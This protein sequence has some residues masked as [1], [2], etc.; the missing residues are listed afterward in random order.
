MNENEKK[1]LLVD[2]KSFCVAPWMS[3]YVHPNGN[4]LPCCIWDL[5]DPLG[6]INKSSLSEIYQ[7][8]KSKEIKG[9][10]LNGEV[11]KQCSSCI[12]NEKLN[13]ES[14]RQRF[15]R[16]HSK[17]VEYV[18]EDI[19]KFHLWDVRITNLC[20]FKCR[21]CYHG[22]SSSWFNDAVSMNL[23]QSDR[24]IITLD[25]TNDFLSQL[26]EHYEHVEEIYFAGGEPLISE[27]HYQILDEIIKRNKQVYLR[28]STNLSKM[29]FKDKHIFDYWSHFNNI[30][31]FP[32]LDGLGSVGEYIRS[33]FKTEVFIDNAKKV[34]EFLT[35]SHIFYTFSF[36]ALNYLH[37]FDMVI[38]LI[39]Q[40][41]I[42]KNRDYSRR[43][44]L[45]INPIYGPDHLSCKW[46]SDNIKNRFKTRLETF[47]QE[48]ELLGVSDEVN[49]EI[50]ELLGSI[51]L[52]SVTDVDNLDRF[53][54]Y[55]KFKK[56]NDTLD[57][58]RLEKFET[59]IGLKFY[60]E[61]NKKMI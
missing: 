13:I 32:S 27:H 11:V 29:T 43:R 39:N 14:Y 21:M 19:T 48:L 26:T 22:F 58:L 16:D 44:M 15:N 61:I 59:E 23:T 8:D 17:C 10:M 45:A 53:D 49:K 20:N 18:E 34:S 9:K 51:Y 2:S 54:L 12:N 55:Q 40:G 1:S 3:V 6:N 47:N 7:S 46:I 57:K 4:V 56:Y 36:G 28:Y 30:T 37:T 33:G 24:A 25:D 42:E 52:F 60:T 5:N 31:L 41:L 50:M 35:N 38:E